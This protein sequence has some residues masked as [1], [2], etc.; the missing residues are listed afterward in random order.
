MLNVAKGYYD[1]KQIV[2]DG[3]D[4]KNLVSGQELIITY[5]TNT[6]PA[7]QKRTKRLDFLKKMDSVDPSGRPAAEIDE[8][9]GSFRD[10]RI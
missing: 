4:M 1:G 5:Y 9:I 8:M 2:I 3:E 6:T 10:D 7:M